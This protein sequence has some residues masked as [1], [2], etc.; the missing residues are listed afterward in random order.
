MKTKIV[1]VLVGLLLAGSSL[2][3]EASDW[4]KAGKILTGI[5]GLRIITGGKVDLIGTFTGINKSRRPRYREREYIHVYEE[6]PRR[7]WVPV[8]KIWKKKW[9]PTHKEYDPELGKIIVEGHYI[10]Y[11]VKRGGY[12]SYKHPGERSYHYSRH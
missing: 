3:A 11:K 2:S 5:E 12:W 7:V 9:I 8:K 6:A 10:K 1:I 4:D